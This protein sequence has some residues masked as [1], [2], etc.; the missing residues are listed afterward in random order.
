M[1]YGPVHPV[2]PAEIAGA[3]LATWLAVAVVL[4]IVVVGGVF[5]AS[6]R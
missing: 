2:P 6:R 4:A 3:S 1:R 5:L